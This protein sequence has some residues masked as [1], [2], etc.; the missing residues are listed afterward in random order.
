MKKIILAL[1]ALVMTLAIP[2]SANADTVTLTL[3]TA[4]SNQVAGDYAYP[5]YLTVGDTANV[6]LMCLNFADDVTFGESWTATEVTL[7]G[8]HENLNNLAA[9]W[10]LQDAISNPGNAVADQLAA[11][12]LFDSTDAASLLLDAPNAQTQLNAAV[13]GELSVNKVDFILYTPE[14]G[15]QTEGGTPQTFIGINPVQTQTPEPSSLL[16]MGTGLLGLALVWS[17][18]NRRTGKENA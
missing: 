8:P 11:W 2:L 3:N 4:G 16:F 7:L 14:D 1:L 6:A 10:L 12:S 13:A 5:Y 9:A 15:T 18:K 17:K